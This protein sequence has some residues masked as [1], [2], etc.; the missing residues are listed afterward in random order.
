MGKS[1]LRQCPSVHPIVNVVKSKM[2]AKIAIICGAICI[3][4][5]STLDTSVRLPK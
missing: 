3:C 4:Y 2:K 5:A 1:V